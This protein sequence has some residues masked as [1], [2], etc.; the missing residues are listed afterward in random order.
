M[1]G[2]GVPQLLPAPAPRGRASGTQHPRRVVPRPAARRDDRRRWRSRRLRARGN[3]PERDA[4]GD[5]D[6]RRIV[7]R[8][9]PRIDPRRR[10][11]RARADAA[12]PGSCG[13]RRPSG[14]RRPEHGIVRRDQQPAR[15]RARAATA[16]RLRRPQRERGESQRRRRIAGARRRRLRSVDRALSIANGLASPL[17]PQP[18]AEE[19]EQRAGRNVDEM[20]LIGREHRDADQREP[21]VQR[22]PRPARHDVRRRAPRGSRAARCAATAPG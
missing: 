13:R 18:E 1:R 4:V 9:R 2:R 14:I 5:R 12:P 20:M 15:P 17:G 10:P 11:D 21:D 3:A 8:P 22:P 19:A 16:R 7:S 6:R